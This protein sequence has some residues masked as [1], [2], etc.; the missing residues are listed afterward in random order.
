MRAVRWHGRGDVR[1]EEIP[2]APLP[3]PGQIRIRVEWAGICGTDREEW[4]TGPHVIQVDRP[5]PLTGRMAPITLGHEIVGRVVDMGPGVAELREDQ[6]VAL[7]GLLTCGR[8]FWCRRHEVTLCEQLASIGFQAD[9]GLA[10]L[11][12]V[13]A[14]GAIPVPEGVAADTAVL[15]E[16]LAVAIRGLRLGRVAPGESVAVFGGGMIG[17]AALRVARRA[18]ASTVSVI[19]PSTLRREGARRLGADAVL[20]PNDPEWEADL[21]AVHDGRG[22]DLVIEAAGTIRSTEQAVKAAR[23]GGRTV[24]LGLPPGPSTVD[25]AALS[26]NERQVIGALSHVW[27]E[28]F[29]TA[30]AML[31]DGILAAADVVAARIPLE[32]T[33]SVG[34]EY[35]GRKDLPGVKILV[36]PHLRG[37]P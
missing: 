28:D 17:L 15:A 16:P 26:L 14:R 22:P 25:F 24:I 32:D 34:L 2:D 35:V 4:R 9:G 5:H 7:D 10:D 36:S 12:T 33:V 1:I 23:R 13:A 20:D 29:A 27:D 6:L 30:V 31:G 37:A 19:A 3:G 8:C 18:G 11:I 21:R